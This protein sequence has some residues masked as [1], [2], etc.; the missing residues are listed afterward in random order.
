M[1]CM[2]Y[3]IVILCIGYAAT[4]K[5]VLMLLF[6]I[7]LSTAKDCCHEGVDAYIHVLVRKLETSKERYPYLPTVN[8]IIKKKK[9]HFIVRKFVQ[10]H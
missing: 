6:G 2:T 10:K 8:Q 4:L 9:V 1:K 5:I 3:I 7:L